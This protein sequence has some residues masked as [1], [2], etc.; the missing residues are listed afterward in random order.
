MNLVMI[1]GGHIMGKNNRL[2]ALITICL[3]TVLVFS[4]CSC[5]GK[6]NSGGAE[7]AGAKTE[8]ETETDARDADVTLEGYFTAH[9]EELDDIREGVSEDESMQ[10]TLKILDFD[11]YAKDNTLYYEYQFKDTYSASDVETMKSKMPATFDGMK[12]D[13]KRRIRIV[14]A[15]YGIDGVTIHIIYKNGDGSVIGEREYSR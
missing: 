14:E 4:M 12:K 3:V 5:G 8:T 9:P 10:N 15:A 2:R 6:K 1:P 11:V 7:K 13:M